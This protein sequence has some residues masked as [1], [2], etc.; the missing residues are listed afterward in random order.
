MRNL[1]AFVLAAVMSAAIVFVA[2]LLFFPGEEKGDS[3]SNSENATA[4]T[5]SQSDSRASLYQFMFLL[6]DEAYSLPCKYSEFE[7]NGWVLR[8]PTELIKGCSNMTDVYIKKARHSLKTEIINY[9]DESIMCC[10]G[11]IHSVS[12]HVGDFQKITVPG[13]VTLDRT[14]TP[15]IVSKRLGEPDFSDE[16]DE[17][18]TL[19]YQKGEYKSVKFVFSKKRALSG[20]DDPEQETDFVN[21]PFESGYYELAVIFECR[22]DS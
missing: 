7:K 8:N 10:K 19:T 3:A 20:M 17:S 2:A 11:Q 15:S 12:A 1:I 5:V 6:D 22:K 13:S 14:T 16:N 18:V 9:S 4:L 21:E